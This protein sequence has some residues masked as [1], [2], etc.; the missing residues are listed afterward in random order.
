MLVARILALVGMCFGGK[1]ERA[2]T[3]RNIVTAELCPVQCVPVCVC[4]VSIVTAAKGV[5][6]ALH[7]KCIKM[8]TCVV[9]SVVWMS[10]SEFFVSYFSNK[11]CCV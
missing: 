10:V 5:V 11:V 7:E 2:T 8:Q 6:K 3:V 9:C 1:K 4:G